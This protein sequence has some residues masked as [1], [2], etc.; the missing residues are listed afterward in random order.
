VAAVSARVR[1]P[2]PERARRSHA[3]RTAETRARVMAAVV[4]SIAEVGYQRTT[5]AEIARRAGVTWGAVQHHFG[6]KDGILMAVLEEAFDDF[7]KRLA[8]A[9]ADAEGLDE[10]VGHF[11]ERSAEHFGSALYRSTFE[12]LLNLP[13]DLELSWQREMLSAWIRIWSRYFPESDTD[14]PRT[15]ELMSYTV[16]VLS[17]LAAT[18]MLE[19]RGQLIGSGELRYLKETLVRALDT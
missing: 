10:R 19:G 16:S 11:V 13:N 6:D 2:A 18:R 14:D 1:I 12:I 5:A 3:Q 15:V 17:G 9:P 7:A 4:E 8:A